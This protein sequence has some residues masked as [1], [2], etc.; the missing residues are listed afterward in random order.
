M[1][2]SDF[3]KPN[4]SAHFIL[5]VLSGADENVATQVAAYLAKNPAV[6]KV[7]FGNQR[8]RTSAKKSLG[9]VG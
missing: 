4:K 9:L 5:Q 7:R 2:L 1:V 3:L 6:I 8:S